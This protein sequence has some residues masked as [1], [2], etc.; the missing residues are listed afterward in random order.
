ML[1]YKSIRF[2]PGLQSCFTINSLVLDAG[3]ISKEVIHA[4]HNGTEKTLIGRLP[5]RKGFPFKTL[6]HEFRI[7]LDKGK[8]R[9]VRGGH[10]YFVL[11]SNKKLT[12]A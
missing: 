12:P 2:Y 5:A 10:V 3:Y 11:L 9:F 1:C 8:Y 7:C 4:F 6:Y